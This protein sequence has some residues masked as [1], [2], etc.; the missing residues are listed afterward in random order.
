[1]SNKK[2]PYTTNK[3]GKKVYCFCSNCKKP[4]TKLSDICLGCEK[5]LL[6]DKPLKHKQ[7]KIGEKI[8]SGKQERGK[9]HQVPRTVVMNSNK[10]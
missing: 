2:H 6:V 5:L 7:K 9:G 3:D 8:S 1:M 10:R 4:N